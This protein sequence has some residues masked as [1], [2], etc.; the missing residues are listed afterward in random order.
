MHDAE[1]FFKKQ[2]NIRLIL[3]L[4]YVNSQATVAKQEAMRTKVIPI[5]NRTKLFFD[6]PGSRTDFV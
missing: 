4:A 1:L 2:E 5:A 3:S 6:K